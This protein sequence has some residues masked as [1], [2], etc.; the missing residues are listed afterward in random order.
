MTERQH[1]MKKMMAERFA[2]IE[3]AL[4]LDTHPND[5]KALKAFGE[6]TEN[7]RKLRNEYENKFG[8][9]TASNAADGK[10]W[11]W[12]CDPWPWD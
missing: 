9:L 2:A 4:F 6:Y 3:T 11:T 7:T 8:A 12:I 5:A 10:S 1:L